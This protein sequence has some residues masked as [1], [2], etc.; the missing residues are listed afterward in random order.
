MTDFYCEFIAL[1]QLGT[2]YCRPRVEK[3]FERVI[4]NDEV[5]CIQILVAIGTTFNLIGL[6]GI[7]LSVFTVKINVCNI[8]LVRNKEMLYPS[9]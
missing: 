4:W 9:L 6:K 8:Y 7:L 2:L 3:N 5:A 1:K